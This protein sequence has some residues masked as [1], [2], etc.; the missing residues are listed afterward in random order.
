MLARY[1]GG[2]KTLEVKAVD[3]FVEDGAK[4]GTKG[5]EVRV[6]ICNIFHDLPVWDDGQPG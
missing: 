4:E 6:R 5:M 1:C 2:G 3:D